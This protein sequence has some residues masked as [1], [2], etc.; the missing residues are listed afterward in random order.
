LF[1]KV[2]C[3][4]VAKLQFR[5]D[6]LGRTKPNGEVAFPVEKVDPGVIAHYPLAILF[7]VFEQIPHLGLLGLILQQRHFRLPSMLDWPANMKT[8]TLG[9]VPALSGSA[10]NRHI[11]RPRT[12]TAVNL[13]FMVCSLYCCIFGVSVSSQTEYHACYKN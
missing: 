13:D 3:D 11:V 12:P 10:L 6:A 4:C 1:V 2:I 9:E 8:F 5:P 7:E